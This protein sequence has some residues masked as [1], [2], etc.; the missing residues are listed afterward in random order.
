[1]DGWT[2]GN[3]PGLKEDVDTPAAVDSEIRKVTATN[4]TQSLPPDATLPPPISPVFQWNTDGQFIQSQ[5][6]G[7]RLNLLMAKLR[8]NTGGPVTSF[9]V[10]YDFAEVLGNVG[11]EVPGL[12]A[13]YSLTGASNSWVALPALNSATNGP[14]TATLNVT[15]W[16]AG[17]ALWLL[18]GDD[19]AS[20]SEGAYTIDN[21]AI[22]NVVPMM[23]P[24]LS[25]TRSVAGT[26][27]LNWTEVGFTLQQSVA[28][29]GTNT[30]WADVLGP[31][32]TGPFQTNNP[33]GRQFYRL[34]P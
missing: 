28:L 34:R 11:E 8:N 16:P 10:A 29:L 25:I 26:V 33:V 12:R 17:R 13:F 3:V 15:N 4:V 21:F 23:Q 19:N 9:E 24:T 31:V 1:M 7:T 14:L 5:P 2:T 32:T 18:W 22:S 30:P 6:T 20:E 27:T